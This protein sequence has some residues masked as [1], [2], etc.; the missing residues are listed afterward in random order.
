[1]NAR[2]P[3]GDASHDPWQHWAATTSG[4]KLSQPRRVLDHPARVLYQSQAT[5]SQRQPAALTH[6]LLGLLIRAIAW[7]GAIV[8]IHD[9]CAPLPQHGACESVF[10]LSERGGR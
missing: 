6:I 3:I 9:S 2:M 5:C 8:K 4:R 10:D 1:M 7:V